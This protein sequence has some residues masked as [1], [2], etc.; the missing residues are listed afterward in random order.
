MRVRWIAAALVGAVC[1]SLAA[2]GH[3]TASKDPNAGLPTLTIGRDNYAPYAYLDGNGNFAG[4][5]I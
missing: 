3:P 1:L 5:D 4:I 2:C